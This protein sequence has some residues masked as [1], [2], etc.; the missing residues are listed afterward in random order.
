MVGVLRHS[1]KAGLQLCTQVGWRNIAL[2]INPPHCTRDGN[3]PERNLQA[4]YDGNPGIMF[5]FNNDIKPIVNPS[6]YNANI[7][8]GLLNV[9]I[10]CFQL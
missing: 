8:A 5:Q 10:Y 1:R 2:D 9:F 6:D 7:T 3:V 4:F